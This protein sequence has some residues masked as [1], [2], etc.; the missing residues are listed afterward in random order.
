MKLCPSLDRDIA[1]EC[2]VPAAPE[3]GRL[4]DGLRQQARDIFPAGAT[5]SFECE[6]D[7][8]LVGSRQITCEKGQWLDDPPVCT[9]MMG[10]LMFPHLTFHLK[11]TIE[12]K[13]S[14]IE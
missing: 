7:Y 5:V 8:S 6:D 10:S 4:L 9:G 1:A 14:K 3:H 11:K 13:S 2:G 12:Q